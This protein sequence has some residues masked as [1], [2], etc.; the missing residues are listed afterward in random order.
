MTK[1]TRL[2]AEAA[3]FTLAL[4]FP[5]LAAGQA[6]GTPEDLLI[7]PARSQEELVSKS[8]Q[9]RIVGKVLQIDRERGLVKI[10]T[11]EGDRMVQPA[12]AI[13]RA[14]RVGDTISVPRPGNEPVSASPRE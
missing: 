2:F 13:V 3:I 11:E 6:P 7:P 8:D 10:A 9:H 5:V 1:G 12:P 4:G 14:I